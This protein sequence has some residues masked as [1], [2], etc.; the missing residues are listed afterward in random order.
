V[1]TDTI[2]LSSL[3]DLIA[4]KAYTIGRRGTWRDYVDLFFALKW[5]IN[6]L[7]TVIKN[8]KKKFKAEFNDRLFLDQLVYYGDF[9]VVPIKFL[10]ESYSEKEIKSFLEEEVRKYLKKVLRKN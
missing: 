6:S 1:A 8:A 3:D 5:K 10:K 4:N 9:K 2:A 7:E